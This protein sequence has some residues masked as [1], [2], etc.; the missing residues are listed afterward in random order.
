MSKM[1]KPIVLVLS[2]DPAVEP[3][4][5]IG[6]VRKIPTIQCREQLADGQT[7]Y[8]YSISTKYYQ[9]EI[10]LC[11]W[12]SSSELSALPEAILKQTEGILIYFDATDRDFLKR[13]PGY[14]SFVTDADIEFGILLCSELQE[15]SDKGITYREAKQF[16]NVLDVIELEP[17]G[18]TEDEEAAGVDE[19]IQAMHNFIWS[20]VNMNRKA[21]DVAG[22]GAELGTSN[23]NEQT[24]AEDERRI[25]EEL[26]GFEKLLIQ[27]MQFRPNT[28]SWTRNERLAYAQEFAEMFDELL[29]DED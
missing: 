13:L 10:V 23:V 20:N 18:E 22:G 25:E 17:S 27:V 26:K 4:A 24:T 11:P 5:L 9:T 19:L 8:V 14:A 28:N 2:A 1:D 21:G 6:K 29:E 16:C 15:E 7:G 12:K 3:E